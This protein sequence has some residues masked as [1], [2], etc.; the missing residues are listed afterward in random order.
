LQSHRRIDGHKT[1]ASD[2]QVFGDQAG[3][4]VGGQ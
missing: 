1:V 2:Q 3:A 4:S